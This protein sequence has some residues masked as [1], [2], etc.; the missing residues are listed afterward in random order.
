MDHFWTEKGL[1]NMYRSTR[2]A[3]IAVYFLLSLTLLTGCHKSTPTPSP[4][5]VPPSPTPTHIVTPE[6]EHLATPTPAVPTPVNVMEAATPTPLPPVIVDMSPEPGEE[7]QPDDPI[8]IRFNVPVDPES[9]RSSLQIM[10]AVPGDIE[11]QDTLVR[12][13]PRKPFPRGQW[14]TVHVTEDLKSRAGLALI[15]PT[16]YRFVIQAPLEVVLHVPAQQADN[17]PVDQPVRIVF[18]R[19]V[20]A[21]DITSVW[22][23]T[24]PWF[25]I[26]PSVKGRIRWVDTATME[27][28]PAHGFIPSTTY[29]VTVSPPLDALDGAPLTAPVRFSFKT[30]VPKVEE[31]NVQTVGRKSEYILPST[32]FTITFTTAVD[33]ASAQGNVYLEDQKGQEIPLDLTQPAPDTLVARPAGPLTLG[34][35]YTLWV[36]EDVHSQ[37]GNVPLAFTYHTSYTVVPPIRV[38]KTKPANGQTDVPPGGLGVSIA[39][40]GIVDEDTL[41]GHIHV[42]PEPTEVFTYFEPYGNVLWLNFSADAQTTYTITLDATVA[43]VFGN[44]LAHPFSLHFTTGDFPPAYNVGL[45]WEA[46]MFD[47]ALPITFSVDARNVETIT[48]RLYKPSPDALS[49]IAPMEPWELARVGESRLGPVQHTWIIHYPQERNVWHTKSVILAKVG[50]LPLDPGVYVLEIEAPMGKK[51]ISRRRYFVVITPYNL[52]LKVDSKEAL[53]WATDLHTGK[54]VPNLPVAVYAEDNVYTTTTDR[55]G[56]A[57]V[58]LNERSPWSPVV[59]LANPD[60]PNGLVSSNWSEGI[61]PWAFHLSGNYAVPGNLVAHLQTDRQVYRPGQTIHWRLIVRIDNDGVYELPPDTTIH[62][63]VDDPTGNTV[64]AQD[65]ELDAMGTASGDIPLAESAA[66]GFYNMWIQGADLLEPPVVL[67]SAYRKPEFE[68]NVKAEPAEV[69]QGDTV[70]VVAQAQ[71]FFGAPVANAKVSYTVTDEPYQFSWTCEGNMCPP[72]AFQERDWWMWEP[73]TPPGEPL[74][75]GTGHTDARGVFTL[76]LPATLDQG[77]GSRRWTVEIS[78]QDVSGQ[79]ISGRTHVVVHKSGVYPGVA[80]RDYVVTTGEEVVADIILV[81]LH[82][83]PVPNADVTFV[84]L[85]EQ[86]HNVRKK[87]PDGIYRWVS[88]VDL[89]PVYTATVHLDEQG[90]GI[91]RFTPDKGG[92]YRLRVLARDAQGREARA[93]TYVWVSG[94]EY[95]SWR[96]ENNDRLFL[97][98]DKPLYKVGETAQVMVPSPYPYPVEALVTLERGT[99][100]K[101]WRTT[102]RTNSE[103]L[104]IP[105]TEDMAPNV[106]VSVFIV[107]GG[108]DAADGVA[109][110]KLGYAELDVDISSY[111]LDVQVIADKD[112]YAPRDTGHITILVSDHEG[113]P[114][115]AAVA[116]AVV[117]KAVLSLFQRPS[118]MAQVFYRKRGLAVFTA[119]SLVKNVNRIR[120]QMEKGGKGGGGGGGGAI[121]PTVREEFLDVAYWRADIRTGPHGRAVVDVPFPDNLTTWAILAWAVDAQTRVGETE[122]DV[123][124]RKDFLLRPVLP[125]FFTVGD[126]VQVGVVAHNL[127]D[128]SLRA[129]LTISVTGATAVGE[130]SRDIVLAPG[131]SEKVTWKVH[132]VQGTSAHDV[133]F[134]WFGETDVAGLSDAVRVRVPIHN[135]A[136]PEVR[137]T[138]GMLPK[139]GRQVEVVF[140]PR[141][142]VPHRG[143]LRLDVDAS[144]AAGMFDSLTYLRHYPWECTE[145]TISRFL[146]NVVTWRALKRLGVDEPSLEAE[147]PDLVYTGVQ[148]LQAQQNKDGGW[149]WW[150]N[151]MSN[152]FLTAYG[153]WALTEAQAAGFDVDAEMM[154]RAE[155]YLAAVVNTYVPGDNVPDNN[156]AAMVL[157]ALT[158]YRSQVGK[159]TTDLTARAVRLF[160]KRDA[161]AHY[162]RALLALT[163]GLLADTA[164]TAK[165]RQSDMDYLHALLADLQQEAIVDATGVHWEEEEVDWWNMNNDIRSTAMVL[166]LMARYDGDNPLAPDVVRWLMGN[167]HGSRWQHTQD[168]AW[169]VVA[170]TDWME[171][172]GELHPDYDY[173]VWL[174]GETWVQGTMTPADVHKTVTAR[175]P[176]DELKMGDPNV[177]QVERHHTFA[178]M[179]SGAL[180]YRLLLTT[181]RPLHEVQAVDK[182]IW[183][184]RWYTVGD[185]DT[186][187]TQARVGDVI[188]VHVKVIAARGLQYFMLEDPYPAGVDPMDVR[189]LTTAQQV[190]APQMTS[191]NASPAMWWDVHW[192]LRDEKAGFFRTFMPAGTYEFTYQVRASIPGTFVVGPATATQMY[193]PEVY[194][195]T[196]TETFTITP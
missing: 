62:V 175:V 75:R 135:P 134:S 47:V 177:V 144:L 129:R 156:R 90:R 57:R 83:Q 125:R 74:S 19:P 13:R 151:D 80:T 168:T 89:T 152:P 153:L 96:R 76:T 143:E 25:Q 164:P 139:D 174:N 38:L 54:P 43:D 5:P 50:Q 66:I 64:Y 117:D 126:E 157:Y 142:R 104:E 107:A 111:V 20:V 150:P 46:A 6:S 91:A 165:A 63:Q 195:R 163:F 15:R 186:P 42:I 49:E 72:Y 122:R 93:A 48:V 67:V 155:N 61:S 82:G 196:G 179:G 53:I 45:P 112:V 16:Y 32:P 24:P 146:P 176:V 100:R 73:F 65:V 147:L 59:V 26:T 36:L 35:T 77:Q 68:L 173:T 27:F 69:V 119:A 98:A 148:R 116:L 185:S 81:D 159:R 128:V 170:L 58:A 37:V 193:A 99:I 88:A 120:A 184:H 121:G 138:A 56:L 131:Q 187:V 87:D 103:V 132:H 97:I 191:E 21:L 181:Y 140:V 136:P 194:G 17:V 171:Q 71:Y 124:V 14:I 8:E 29:T 78:V 118:P 92:T 55:E 189:L 95:V 41:A 113:H 172:T 183:V 11:V 123:I 9:V 85:R 10:P 2:I 31:V 1:G 22:M 161:M 86:W 40:A 33:L 108:R 60:Q 110:F 145:Q 178:Q 28:Q 133:V 160:E 141:A 192:E 180:Y 158:S 101:V 167:R 79:V 109:T 188:T 4:T 115:D 23:D 130:P 94:R 154:E 182:G 162:G 18:N 149:G 84:A 169:A 127:S 12:F 3:Q 70:T 39:F 106:F 105:I 34:E 114:A 166:L 7:A 190:E 137:A 44:T 51:D 30:V 52:M 102:L